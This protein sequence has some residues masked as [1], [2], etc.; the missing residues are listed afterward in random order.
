[1]HLQ[2]NIIPHAS[3]C[4]LLLRSDSDESIVLMTKEVF[5]SG[6]AAFGAKVPNPDENNYETPLKSENPCTAKCHLRGFYGSRAGAL[7]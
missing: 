1:M 7:G 6:N 5:S 4:D 3:L 2:K